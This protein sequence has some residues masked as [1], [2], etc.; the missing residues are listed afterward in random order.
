MLLASA[1]LCG[2]V[3]LGFLVICVRM[4]GDP[5]VPTEPRERIPYIFRTFLIPTVCTGATATLAV[6]AAGEWL[7]PRAP[8]DR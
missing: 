7:Y 5:D 4:L 2:L 8:G 6:L 3:A 1:V